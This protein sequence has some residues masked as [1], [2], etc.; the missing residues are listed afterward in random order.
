MKRFQSH[1]LRLARK[2]AAM[3]NQPNDGLRERRQSGAVWPLGV[4][5]VVG[6]LSVLGV[7]YTVYNALRERTQQERIARSAGVVALKTYLRLGPKFHPFKRITY[8]LEAAGG[9][10][11]VNDGQA[12]RFGQLIA[13]REARSTFEARVVLPTEPVKVN[14]EVGAEGNSQAL[15]TI[16]LGA[17]PAGPL[18]CQNPVLE[19]L[20]VNLATPVG[21]RTDS[22]AV[23]GALVRV[24]GLS[25]T[26]RRGVL[27]KLF[28]LTR[29]DRSSTQV[30]MLGEMVGGQFVFRECKTPTTPTPMPTPTP[31]QEQIQA[32]C[33]ALNFSRPIRDCSNTHWEYETGTYTAVKH[34]DGTW[35]CQLQS[36]W[37]AHFYNPDTDCAGTADPNGFTGRCKENYT[38]RWVCSRRHGVADGTHSLTGFHPCGG[39]GYQ[40]NV[41]C[42]FGAFGPMT[43]VP[44]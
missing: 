21:Q 35:K 7:T 1:G 23:F 12:N 31:S 26:D 39:T 40:L 18:D 36:A 42:D 33:N 38:L 20:S 32:R 27:G 41:Q 2:G 4:V 22:Q 14:W 15:G 29:L 9:V 10:L 13:P 8:S 44:S 5:A 30:L 24:Q 43:D 17:L 25:A 19:P 37:V 3:K 11:K 16:T 34:P 6:I 28:G